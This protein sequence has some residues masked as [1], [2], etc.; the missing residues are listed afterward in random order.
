M[1]KEIDRRIKIA[2]V[3]YKNTLPF[4]YG[5]DHYA[6]SFKV[7]DLSLHNPAEC[8]RAF[9]ADIVDI[10]LVPAA[11]LHKHPE[12]RVITDACIGSD[13]PVSSVCLLSNTS[14][15]NVKEVILDNH[16]MTSN[17]LVKVLCRNL[18]NIEP[19]YLKKDVSLGYD[20]SSENSAVVMIGDKVFEFESQYRYKYDLGNYWKEM[21]NLP[22]V[23]AV[24]VAKKHVPVEV[25][26]KLNRILELGVANIDTI[27][28]NLSKEGLDYE[29]YLK[30]NLKYNFSE[31]Y[32]QGL[33]RYL[34]L[35]PQE[36]LV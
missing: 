6:D 31:N 35:I 9:L 25:I 27:L 28:S 15:Q 12:T 11:F 14:I 24:W 8:A 18:W 7:F 1:D 2:M 10:A 5:F 29:T 26:D 20:L 19:S 13:G 34:S 33:N 4:S 21:T 32:K 22:F 36:S 30:L 17:A 16:S 23:F 3:S